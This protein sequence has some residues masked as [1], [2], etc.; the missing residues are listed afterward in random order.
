VAR[1]GRDR[2]RQ[3]GGRVGQTYT[4]WVR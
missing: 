2:P 4:G 1:D 3:P